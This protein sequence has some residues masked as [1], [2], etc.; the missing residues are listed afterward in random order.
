IEKENKKNALVSLKKIMSQFNIVYYTAS[1]RVKQLVDE[2]LVFT[3]KYGKS[4]VVH[5][6]EKA[7]TLLTHRETV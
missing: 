3:K 6:T 1:K 4:R 2:G 5:L 7:K